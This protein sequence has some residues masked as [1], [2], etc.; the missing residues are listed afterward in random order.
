[1]AGGSAA[2][3]SRE[4]KSKVCQMAHEAWE[5]LGRPMFEDEEMPE[6]MRMGKSLSFET[7]RQLEQE[8]ATGKRSLRQMGQGDFCLAMAHF[9]QLAE[10]FDAAQFWGERA[11]SDGKR[12]ALWQLERELEQAGGALGHAQRYAAAVAVDKFGTADFSQLDEKQVWELVF[13]VRRAAARR[14][15]REAEE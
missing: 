15:Q 13:T 6:D 10:D 8:R 14:R 2:G 4:Q 11:R 5:R 12:R 9:A 1:M 3:L 7:W